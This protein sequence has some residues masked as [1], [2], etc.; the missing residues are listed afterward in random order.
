MS[1]TKSR[2]LRMLIALPMTMG[3]FWTSTQVSRFAPDLSEQYFP[4]SG[5]THLTMLIVSLIILVLFSKNRLHLCGFT[6]GN[7]RLR[8]SFF[9]WFLPTAVPAT[10]VTLFTPDVES[11]H[12]VSDFSKIQIVL[13]VWVLA[14]ISEEI[15]VRGLFQSLAYKNFIGSPTGK[16]YRLSIQVIF[17]GLLFGA[18]HLGLLRRMGAEAVPVIVLTTILG[19]VTA[20]YRETTGSIVP[21]ILIH[22]MFNIGGQLPGWIFN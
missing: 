1:V 21:A 11:S 15:A 2:R 3:V 17:S 14:S 4:R 18:M 19:I 10:L 8:P 16:W 9:L 12:P 13:F 6:M 7:F 20:K 22:M 5:W